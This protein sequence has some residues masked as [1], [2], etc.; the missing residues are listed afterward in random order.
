MYGVHRN[1]NKNKNKNKAVEVIEDIEDIE[2]IEV[3]DVVDVTSSDTMVTTG[4]CSTLGGLTTLVPT[5]LLKG[6][7]ETITMNHVMNPSITD[8]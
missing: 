4:M 7:E 8:A 6:V 2:D 5:M 3:H 1:K